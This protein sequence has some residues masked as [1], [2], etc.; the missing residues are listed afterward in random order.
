MK[1]LFSSKKPEEFPDVYLGQWIRL[2]YNPLNIYFCK[3]INGYSLGFSLTTG[4]LSL[5]SWKQEDFLAAY[6]IDSIPTGTKATYC[7]H[8]ELRAGDIARYLDDESWFLV[9]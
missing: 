8:K 6:L 7:P 1:T 5:A 2:K 3:S 9:G 4:C